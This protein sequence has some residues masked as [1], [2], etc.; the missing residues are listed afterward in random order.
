M[1]AQAL[2]TA[3]QVANYIQVHEQTVWEWAR[4]GVIPCI[5]IG[6]KYR[7]REEEIE[8]WLQNQRFRSG[9]R[10]RK[11]MDEDLSGF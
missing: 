7:F 1:T 9:L 11:P 6:R 10:S 3:R 2:W 4:D 8:R 5:R